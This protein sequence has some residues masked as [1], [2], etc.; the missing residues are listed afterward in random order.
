[1]S[2][3]GLTKSNSLLSTES[4]DSIDLEEDSY[5]VAPEDIYYDD[6][7]SGNRLLVLRKGEAVPVLQTKYKKKVDWDYAFRFRFVLRN[8]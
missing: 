1:M 3:S 5:S 4:F 6:L 7:Q 2:D 8:F